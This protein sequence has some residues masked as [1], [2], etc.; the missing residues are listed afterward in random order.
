MFQAEQIKRMRQAANLFKKDVAAVYASGTPLKSGTARK[1]P[2]KWRTMKLARGVRARV[3][4]TPAGDVMAIIGP[5][6]RVFYGRF[7]E[8][9]I[10]TQVLRDNAASRAFRKE[11]GSRR[12][13]AR[14]RLRELKSSYRFTLKARPV[15]GPAFRRNVERAIQI[16]GDSYVAFQGG[17]SVSFRQPVFSPVSLPRAA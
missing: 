14:T 12:R 9:G 2:E 3:R 11:F 10:D 7:H 1:N 8:T 16:V 6:P 5:G 15:V 17:T 13:A 4:K